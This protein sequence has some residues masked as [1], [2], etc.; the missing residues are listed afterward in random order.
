MN[1]KTV[2]VIAGPT[3]SGKSQLA[4]DLSLAVNGVILNAD[5]MQ[6]YQ[7][8]SVLS[9]AP[10]TEDKQKVKHCLYEIFPNFFNSSVIDWLDKVVP[11]IKKIWSEDKV[12]ILVGGTGLYID[13]LI[14]G[15]TPVPETSNQARQQVM[16]LLKQEGVN[17]LHERLKVIDK[18]IAQKLS[19]NDT[20]R[21][22]RAYEVYLD[23]KIP[24][25]VWHKKEKIKKLPEAKFFVIKIMPTQK[26]LDERCYL[27]FDKMMTQGALEEVK[28][29]KEQNL[30]KNLPAMKAL[31]VPELMSYLDGK[32]SLEEA[33]ELAKLHTRQY[34]KRQL[35]WFKKQLK[36]DKEICYC[37]HTDNDLIK[38]IVLGVK[39]Q[40]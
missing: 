26:E 19:P 2:I 10:N 6:I 34:A 32:M 23:T 16:E 3:A 35:T 17:A 36:A 25:S 4:I 28:N 14:N 38:N 24:L 30:D 18:E 1:K 8:I 20:T 33:I 15:T 39:N 7:G 5:S 27:R 13:N 31:G 37:Y 22:R 21:I 29:L 40:L 11:E 12:P 9:A